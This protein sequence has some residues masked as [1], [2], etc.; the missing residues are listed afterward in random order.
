MELHAQPGRRCLG[1]AW[2]RKQ[3][4][5]EASAAAAAW[6]GRSRG[7]TGRGGRGRQLR[8]CPVAQHLGDTAQKNKN[9][10][11]AI[12]IDN[13][14]Q[15]L[16]CGERINI[17]MQ[18]FVKSKSVLK[19]SQWMTYRNLKNSEASEGD[20]QIGAGSHFIKILMFC[21]RIFL[22]WFWFFKNITLKYYLPA[23]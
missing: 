21:S 15:F 10:K 1:R 2:T 9:K 16:S 3:R 4:P 17:L 13:I 14:F 22:H 5:L 7:N 19:N 11:S 20:M 8:H 18:Y 12:K 6:T 23:N